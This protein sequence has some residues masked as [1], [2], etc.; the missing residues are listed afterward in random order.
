MFFSLRFCGLWVSCE[1]AVSGGG[2]VL[3]REEKNGGRR[4]FSRYLF[5][6]QVSTPLVSFEIFFLPRTSQRG[7]FCVRCWRCT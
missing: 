4:F 6:R 3:M 5:L 1:V 7:K 2:K